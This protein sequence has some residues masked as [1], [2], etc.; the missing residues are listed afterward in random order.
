MENIDPSSKQK[1]IQDMRKIIF[2]LIIGLVVFGTASYA[3]QDAEYSMY[4]FNGLYI[5]PAYAG[6]KDVLSTN[7]L[8]RHQWVG[9]KGA[10]RS[11]SIGIHAPF[12]RNQYAMGGL[13]TFDKL[14]L[15]QTIGAYVDYAYRLR[16]KNNSK[17]SFGIQAGGTYY[18]S[19]LPSA[20]LPTSPDDVVFTDV[21]Q[22][23]LPNMG[24]GV[25]YYSKRF[26]IGA[27]APHILNMS[28]N[29]KWSNEANRTTVAKM[30]NHYIFTLGGV[31]GKDEA[32]VKFKPSALLKYVRNSPISTDVTASFLFVN[33]L[34]L[35]ASYRFGWLGRDDLAL[36]ERNHLIGLVEF[37]V[38]QQFR[39]GYAYDYEFTKLRT[40]TSGSHEIMLG[41]DFGY[42]KERFVTPRYVTYF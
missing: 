9:I 31:I 37:L 42:S 26:Y 27:A 32:T 33:R 39:V 18:K 8:Y 2:S 35:G 17:L 23:F 40:N 28:L 16:F 21:T 20:D 25:Y 30:Y 19:D 1:K 4:M 14:G 36:Q 13:I 3:Q 10:P 41:Y 6:S 5:N 38:T 34:W 29:E 11:A 15:D 24:F 22:L 12:K 7:A